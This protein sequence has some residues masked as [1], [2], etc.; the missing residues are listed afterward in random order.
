MMVSQKRFKL[1]FL[2]AGIL[3][4][5]ACDLAYPVTV[6]G[7]DGTTF[8][9]SATNTFLEGGSFQT[10]N[11]TAVCVGTYTQ[12]ADIKQVSFPVR[13]NNGLTG[14]GTAFFQSPTQ[15]SGFVTMRDGSRWQFLFGKGALQI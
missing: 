3:A 9:G 11:G 6:I 14:I 1:G 2:A 4:L 12:N 15:G 10:T 8:R 7:E 13:C 5:S